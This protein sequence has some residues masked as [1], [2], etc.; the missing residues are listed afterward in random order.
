MKKIIYLTI[1]LTTCSC[2]SKKIVVDNTISIIYN[3]Y[4]IVEKDYDSIIN[5]LNEV[6]FSCGKK[7]NYQ[8]D[9]L[10]V[11]TNNNFYQFHISSNYYMEFQKNDKYCYTKD[12]EK[13][14]NMINFLNQKINEYTD[15]SFFTIRNETNY[16]NNAND[17]IIKLD[18][19]DNFII[20]NINLPITNFKIN[21]I[22]YKEKTDNYIETDLLYSYEEV[23]KNETIIIRKDILQKPNFIISFTN[24]YNYL[25]TILPI[26]NENN[27]INF[28]TNI[29]K[30]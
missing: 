24:I 25:V 20:I 8:G 11:T 17:M 29:N 6:S 18:K 26:I 27:E 22:E 10:T 28:I 19:K 9:M 5:T 30:N 13:I 2:S 21:E 15:L 7:Q 14:K 3:N 1:I 4:N 16:I 23:K 12:T